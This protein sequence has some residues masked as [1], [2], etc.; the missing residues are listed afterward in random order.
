MGVS[1]NSMKQILFILFLITFTKSFAQSD[2]LD[3]DSLSKL[4]ENSWK[5]FNFQEEYP[6]FV[7]D[8]DYQ[9]NIEEFNMNI[10]V[11]STET[12]ITAYQQDSLIWITDPWVDKKLEIYR[13]NR[14]V[15]TCFK[16]W[17]VKNPTSY[18]EKKGQKLIRIVYSNSQ[19]GDIDIKN[20]SFTFLGQ[21]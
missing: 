7:G 18:H 11:D 21:D 8:F 16:L 3:M 14:P 10:I 15:I 5:N 12:I 20:G 9:I 19:F 1:K 4:I 13:H 17:T 2:S 6:D